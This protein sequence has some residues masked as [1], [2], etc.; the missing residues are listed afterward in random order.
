MQETTGLI[1]NL[2]TQ[3]ASAFDCFRELVQNS[4]DAGSPRV[5]VW[6]EFE[7]GEDHLGTIRLTVEDIGEDFVKRAER[8]GCSCS[9]FR[10]A[11]EQQR[12]RE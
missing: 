4:I 11:K 7:A 12:K 1:D 10:L 8:H 3:F 6:T 9:S 5:E 2:V